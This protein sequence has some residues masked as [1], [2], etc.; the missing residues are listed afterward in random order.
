MFVIMLAQLD[1]A[2]LIRYVI[3]H[4]QVYQISTHTQ[5]THTHTHTNVPDLHILINVC[6]YLS[7]CVVY[8][9]DCG[10]QL[11]RFSYTTNMSR[12]Q[13]SGYMQLRYK[14]R[15]HVNIYHFIP[16]LAVNKMCLWFIGDLLHIYH[17]YF[18]TTVYIQQ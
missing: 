3:Q 9:S 2:D 14:K 16:Q 6:V 15:K 17:N 10:N 13:E 18:D 7:M 4:T 12:P 11:I 5:N 1:R 8:S